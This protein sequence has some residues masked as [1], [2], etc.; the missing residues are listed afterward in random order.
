MNDYAVS[1]IVLV[2]IESVIPDTVLV[3]QFNTYN[4]LSSTSESHK[5]R[6]HFLANFL[7]CL[8]P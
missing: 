4:E 7:F 1:D 5:E 3:T 8:K 2:I 6:N